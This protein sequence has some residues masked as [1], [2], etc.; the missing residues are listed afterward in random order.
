M[1]QAPF[2]GRSDFLPPRA[3]R[4]RECGPS[5][6]MPRR[7]SSGTPQIVPRWSPLFNSNGCED[8]SQNKK[9]GKRNKVGQEQVFLRNGKEKRKGIMGWEKNSWMLCDGWGPTAALM[10]EPSLF[11]VC[12]CADSETQRS[13]ITTYSGLRLLT[14]TVGNSHPQQIRLLF[15][16]N[17]KQ[18]LLIDLSYVG[19]SSSSAQ[20]A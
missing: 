10:S 12:R 7:L 18:G 3:C 1:R 6:Q 14:Y 5:Y 8:C 9:Q 19:F 15:P 11:A 16:L 2:D 13:M 17:L 20:R 4:R